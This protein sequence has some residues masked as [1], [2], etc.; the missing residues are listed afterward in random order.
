MPWACEAARLSSD[1]DDFVNHAR[2]PA[3]ALWPGVGIAK[4]F[5]RGAPCGRV[6]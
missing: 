6:A 1:S 2:A 5:L 3:P 4:T